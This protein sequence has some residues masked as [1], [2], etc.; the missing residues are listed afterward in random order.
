MSKLE[1]MGDKRDRQAL[2]ATIEEN[3][4]KVY[5]ELLD[6]E[7]PDRFQALLSQLRQTS[8]PQQNGQQSGQQT[9][10]TANGSAD[11]GLDGGAASSPD[12]DGPD[13]DG[14]ARK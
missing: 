7:V 4:R 11:S 14:E 9:R 13:F 8:T 3:L 5:Q 1:K 6:E 12:S 10:Q 2:K